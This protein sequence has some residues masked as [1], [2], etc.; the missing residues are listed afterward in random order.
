M[1]KTAGPTHQRRGG[2]PA[3]VTGPESGRPLARRLLGPFRRP[4]G[5]LVVGLVLWGAGLV[6]VARAATI[7]EFVIPTANSG[8]TGIAAGPDGALWFTEFNGNKVGRI[9]TAGT[10][11]E[12]AAG[13]RLQG[14][15][16]G[17][18][19]ALWFT[20]AGTNKIGRITTAGALTE[21][22]LE[23]VLGS[24][25]SEPTDITAGPDGALWFTQF[26][27]NINKIGRITTS[28]TI[29]AFPVPT[30]FSGPFNITA[31][32]DGALW[33]TER[34]GDKIGRITTAGTITEFPIPTPNSAPRGITAGPDGALWF[35]ERDGNKIGRI[36]T[37]G[38]ITEFPIPTPNSAPQDITAGP[39]GAL[40]FTEFSGN[41]IGRTVPDLS[42]EVSLNGSVFHTGQTI[43]FQATLFPGIA[44]PKVDIYLGALL[45]DFVTFLSLVQVSPGVIS[46]ALGPA[47]IP[48]LAN[49][50]LTLTV[51]PFSYTFTGPEP[52][53]TYF[54]YAGI[55]VAGSNPFQPA[56]RLSLAVQAFE[57][58]P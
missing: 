29:T 22:V 39:D 7:T 48:F 31:G 34:E 56:N 24:F 45:P 2:G 38:I 35:T 28:G 23:F 17:P 58:T 16:A 43:T 25:S 49:A 30:A 37:A 12:F 20:E 57:F 46:I 8:P 15:T 50:T 41:R 27:S 18:D 36:T 19:G 13:S 9:T 10:I 1:A 11:T 52:A 44:P 3:H 26:I 53:G 6:G 33:F 21:F 42:G 51:V 4:R 14:I 54:P 32:P 40:W 47:P 55:T 5:V